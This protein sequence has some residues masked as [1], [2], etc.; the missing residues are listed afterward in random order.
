MP[1]KI[2]L[3]LALTFSTFAAYAISPASDFSKRESFGAVTNFR[4]EKQ[5]IDLTVLESDLQYSDL[6]QQGIQEMNQQFVLKKEY[7][8]MIG[9]N[10]WT[11]TRQKVIDENGVRTFILE[12]H[13]KNRENQTVNFLE[14]YYADKSQSGQFLVTSNT[15]KL[16][17]DEYKKFFNP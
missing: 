2:I 12:G 11:A 4:D 8:K 15:K 6:G 10:D 14:I 1:T 7:G 3:V 9:F 13:Y 16:S 17:L 5:D